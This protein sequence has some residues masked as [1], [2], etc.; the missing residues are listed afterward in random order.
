MERLVVQAGVGEVD[1]EPDHRGARLGQ[2]LQRLGV[3]AAW[4]R[5]AAERLQAGVVDADDQ[6]AV[7]RLAGVVLGGEPILGVD[8]DVDETPVAMGVA[9]QLLGV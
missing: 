4:D 9:G 5:V 6:H 8:R 3:L 2:G 7:V 1:V